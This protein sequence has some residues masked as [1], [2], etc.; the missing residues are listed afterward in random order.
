MD[1]W[2]MKGTFPG[3]RWH[4]SEVFPDVRGLEVNGGKVGCR[5]LP[6]CIYLFTPRVVLQFDI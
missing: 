2:G 1:V 4:S 6:H 5:F 3:C